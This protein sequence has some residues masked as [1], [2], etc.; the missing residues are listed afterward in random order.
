MKSWNTT[1][2]ME[3][4]LQGI[5]LFVLLTMSISLTAQEASPY[6]RFGPGF[7]VDQTSIANRSMGGL[8][9][10]YFSQEGIN[11]NNPASYAHIELVSF[12]GAFSSY[13]KRLKQNDL[14]ERVA[15][16]NLA[17]M[18]FSLPIQ[19]YWGV[20]LGLT[21]YISKNYAFRDTIR[22]ADNFTVLNEFEGSG[23][24]YKF[25]FGNGFKYKGTALGFNVGYLFGHLNND[26]LGL[27]GDEDGAVDPY[28]FAT[29][30]SSRTQINGFVWDVGA[31]Y[32]LTLKKADPKTQ[33]NGLSLNLGISG[34]SNYNLEKGINIEGGNYTFVGAQINALR[35]ENQSLNDFL[36]GISPNSLDTVGTGDQSN[37][38]LTLPATLNAGFLIKKGNNWSTGMDFSWTPY[39][40]YVGFEGNDADKLENGWRVAV[41]GEFLPIAGKSGGDIRSKFFTQLKYRAGFSFA[42]SPVS[43]RGTQ[44][45]EFGINFGLAIPVLRTY[46]SEEGYIA[47]RGV[48]AFS[49]GFGF[50]SRGT[51][52]DN[53]VKE[54]FFN[55]NLGLSLNDKWFV[56]R[57]YN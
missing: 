27:V 53:L 14:S 43:V 5:L 12:E 37:V 49:L 46:T 41:G 13:V 36:T 4:K 48:H 29:W 3:N 34:H 33:K 21:P 40:N 7:F 28:S 23:T 57:R 18:T 42:K 55:I 9:A 30:K 38:P 44:I 35:G 8:N 56:K 25:F 45:N 6:S 47:Q 50:G 16:L 26:I 19:D 54:N 20:T 10:T 17:Y 52:N 31:M 22:T 11:I 2:N 1:Y 32:E 39:S 15:D 24:I 51:L